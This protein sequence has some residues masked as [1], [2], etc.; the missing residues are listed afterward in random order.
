MLYVFIVIVSK[1]QR[2]HLF[3]VFAFQVC[4]PSSMRAMPLCLCVRGGTRDKQREE[5]DLER[6]GEEAIEGKTTRK[7]IKKA[8][9]IIYR[10][11]KRCLQKRV[12]FVAIRA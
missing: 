9:E 3:I 2:Y 8:T 7:I 12:M 4:R 5:G 11:Q 1:D 6:E 10:G